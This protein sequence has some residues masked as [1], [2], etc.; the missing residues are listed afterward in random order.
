MITSKR[1]LL[2]IIHNERIRIIEETKRQKNDSVLSY[3]WKKQQRIEQLNELYTTTKKELENELTEYRKY[4]INYQN[5]VKK[6]YIQKNKKLTKKL[7]NQLKKIDRN[8][9]LSKKEKN[10]KKKEL[11][12]NNQTLVKELKKSK[13]KELNKK[14][15]DVKS[16]KHTYNEKTKRHTYILDKYQSDMEKVLTIITDGNPKIIICYH[17]YLNTETQQKEIFSRSKHRKGKNN[18]TLEDIIEFYENDYLP[19]LMQIGYI[20]T[21]LLDENG[22]IV[23]Y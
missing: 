18:I 12:K 13:K 1:E 19:L 7:E 22:F 20:D 3:T 8:K 14:A 5:K 2:S 9:K 6:E 17:S 21:T 11:K 23:Y 4:L 15:K 16:Y 10:E